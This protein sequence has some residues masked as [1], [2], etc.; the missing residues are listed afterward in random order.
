M[1]GT[2][3]SSN[4]TS[5]PVSITP[6]SS[7][8]SPNPNSTLSGK[9]TKNESS[10][11]FTS[12]E[13]SFL[14]QKPGSSTST[15]R[16]PAS[17]SITWASKGLR[18]PTEA[19]HNKKTQRSPKQKTSPTPNPFNIA[20]SSKS[21]SGSSPNLKDAVLSPNNS[22]YNRGAVEDSDEESLVIHE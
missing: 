12:D 2:S 21:T 16:L 10:S 9:N 5:T 22:T 20:A 4:L 11:S 3:I 17:V 7:F 18:A 15:P 8:K 19:M 13:V 14:L 1:G 6:S